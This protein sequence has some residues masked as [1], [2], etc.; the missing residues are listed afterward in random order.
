MEK[1]I[2]GEK[3]VLKQ[4]NNKFNLDTLLLLSFIKIPLTAKKVVDIGTG[5]GS[6]MIYLSAQ[7]KAKLI[8]IEIQKDRC[9]EALENIRLNKLEEQVTCLNE[10]VNKVTLHN[11]DVVIAN[12]PFFELTAKTKI[13]KSPSEQIGRFE[14]HLTLEQLIA[15][16][17]TFLKNKGQFYFIHR[18]ERITEIL[19]LLEKHKMNVKR[20]QYV[21]P[22]L[23]QEAKHVLIMATKNGAFNSIVEKPF[24]LY[25]EK[26]KMTQQLSAL[27]GGKNVT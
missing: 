20:I 8:G 2:L 14:T 25:Q 26:Q 15:R 4:E 9:F 11:V 7:T 16:A 18:P 19:L 10:D 12:P 27:Y 22:Y 1:T 13:S 24:I 5:N 6:M 17:A 23:D 21:H 3:I